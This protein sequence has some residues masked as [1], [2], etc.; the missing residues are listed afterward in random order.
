MPIVIFN[1]ILVKF[2]IKKCLFYYSLLNFTIT[3]VSC[4]HW[5]ERANFG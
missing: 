5:T 4:L 2:D 3:N 1:S